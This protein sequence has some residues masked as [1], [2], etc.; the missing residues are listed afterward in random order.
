M[1]RKRKSNLSQ[2]SNLARA[3]KVAGFNETFSQ[4][5]Q[6]WNRRSVR[7]ITELLRYQSSPKV[8]V[9]VMSNIWHLNGLLRH[10]NSSSSASSACN[11]H[12]VS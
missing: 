9:D 12:G 10:P 8:G 1:P 7:Q 4:A 3:K 5:E 11:L 6:G 2:C